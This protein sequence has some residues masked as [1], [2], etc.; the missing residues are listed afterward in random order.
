VARASAEIISIT[1]ILIDGHEERDDML[2]DE[3]DKSAVKLA[4]EAYGK[5]L[6]FH[7]NREITAP[8]PKAPDDCLYHYTTADGLKGIIEKNELWATSAYFLNDSAEIIYGCRVLKEA[9]DEWIASNPRPEDSLTLGT[10]RQLQTAFGEHFLNMHVVQPIYLACF[11]EGDNV[12]SQWRTYGQSGGYS[13]G[14]QAPA[15][16][17]L[18][19]QGFKPEPCTYTSKWVKVEYDKK[20]QIRRCKETL[21]AILPA[22]EGSETT[23]AF[24]V[25]GDHPLSGYSI[26]LKTMVDILMEEIVRFK[27][28]AFA[29]EKEW[30]V[31]VRQR[32]LTKQGTDDAG[33]TRPPIHFRPSRGALVPYVKLIPTNPGDKLPIYCVR[34]GPTLDANAA[35]LALPLFLETNGYRLRIRRSEISLRL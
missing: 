32:E 17:F 15:P 8:K 7:H 27:N 16:D 23:Q 33:K 28:E 18:T 31:V 34:T 20:E 22:F 14:F 13:L 9:L 4:D 21:D 6:K 19:G 26:V 25:I 5:V 24:A 12:L 3:Y 11:C 1:I 29:V 30:R 10:A 2:L 35:T